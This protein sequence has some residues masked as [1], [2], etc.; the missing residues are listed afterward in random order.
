MPCEAITSLPSSLMFS[1]EEGSV[2][3]RVKS[4]AAAA[5]VSLQGFP[6]VADGLFVLGGR[7]QPS[8]LG[9]KRKCYVLWS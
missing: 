2:L 6:R 9:R 8:V 4:W 7:T 3:S 1:F 5:A